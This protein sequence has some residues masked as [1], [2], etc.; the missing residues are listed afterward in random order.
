[1]L[2]RRVR[3]TE[4]LTVGIL[5]LR[6]GSRGRLCRWYRSSGRHGLVLPPALLHIVLAGAR[7]GRLGV[8]IALE[9]EA[10]AV[11]APVVAARNGDIDRRPAH[12]ESALG[13]FSRNGNIDRRPAHQEAT[14]GLGVEHRD[15]LG[16]VVGLAAQRLASA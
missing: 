14:L 4:L 12:H 16:A 1:R 15:E 9:K 3:T 8:P 7:I 11:V 10:E 5:T 13:L 6:D 2:K